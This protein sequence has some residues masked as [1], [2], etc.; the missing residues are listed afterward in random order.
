MPKMELELPDEVLDFIQNAVH[1]GEYPN[2]AAYLKS[3]VD[4]ERSRTEDSRLEALLIEGL[5]S[6]EPI[7]VTP[8]F[9][10]D[11]RRRTG[12]DATGDAAAQ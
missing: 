7:P 2:A 11:L 9:W 5:E 4:L 8:E 12:L 3:L 10:Q 1:R 6:G